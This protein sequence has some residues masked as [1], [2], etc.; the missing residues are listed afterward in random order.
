MAMALL[1]GLDLRDQDQQEKASQALRMNLPGLGP[2]PA[3]PAQ[4]GGLADAL[5]KPAA[6]TSV[7]RGIRNNNPLNIEAGD[8]TKGQPGFTGSDGRFAQFG[9]MDQGTAAANKLLDTYQNKYGLNTVG[10]IVNRWAP[11]GENDSRGYAA[12]VAG[13]MGVGADQPLTPEQRP[14]LIAAMGQFENGRPIPQQ[15]AQADPA[16]LPPNSAPAAGQIPTVPQAA[17]AVTPQPNAGAQIPQRSPVQIDPQ[18]A[19][20]IRTMIGSKDPAIQQ[21]GYALYQQFAKPREETRP[22]TNPQD[23]ARYGIAPTDSNPY[24]V[25]S[26]GEVKPINPQPFNVNVNNQGQSEFEKHYGEGQAKSALA[27]LDRGNAA[28]DKL[29]KIEL[30]QSLLQKVQTGKL[31]PAQATIGAWAEASA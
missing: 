19:Q 18:M 28:V 6:D 17:P 13:R 2:Q 11:P 23:R 21:Q 22:L 14:A 25:D 27:T 4:S 20:Q 29:Q 5:A 26:K 24:Q 31:A 10:G 9:S 3:Q 16:A 30:T 8:F 7:P 15:A 12:S 1:A